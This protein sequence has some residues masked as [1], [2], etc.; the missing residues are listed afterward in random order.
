MIEMWHILLLCCLSLIVV[1]VVVGPAIIRSGQISEERR[2]A[3]QNGTWPYDE[4]SVIL[5]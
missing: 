1:V 3:F 4:D 5:H 2:K